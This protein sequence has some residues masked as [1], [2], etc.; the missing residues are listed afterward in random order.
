MKP[1]FVFVCL[2]IGLGAIQLAAC[3]P[4]P[5]QETAR[6]EASAEAAEDAAATADAMVADAAAAS[7][8]SGHAIAPSA[9]DYAV[10]MPGSELSGE[11]TL[12]SGADGSGG[13]VEFANPAAPEDVIAFYRQKAEAA[14]L[15]TVATMSRDGTLSYTASDGMADQGK[16]LNVVAS[17]TDSGT[18]VHLD[19]SGGR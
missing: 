10:Y 6:A 14:G 3:Q 12:A 7:E 11:P 15:L 9:P 18:S 8:P 17:P 2:G 4:A 1:A 5:A 19:W 16:L 13:M